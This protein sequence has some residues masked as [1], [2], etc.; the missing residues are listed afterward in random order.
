LRAAIAKL[1]FAVWFRGAWQVIA[2]LWRSAREEFVLLR[3][4]D[5]AAAADARAVPHQHQTQPNWRTLPL[6][7]QV[8][9]LYA[10]AMQ[11]AQANGV[12]RRSSQTPH[13][14]A[15][16]LSHAA[17]DAQPDVRE[18][19]QQFVEARYSQHAMQP[20]QVSLA[21]RCVKQIRRVLVALRK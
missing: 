7:Q 2:R 15:E 18:L 12:P 11:H 21:E 16:T 4:R 19:T 10:Q 13:E 8:A 17:P 6:R 20:E 1:P 5:E 9:W 3:Q 14:F